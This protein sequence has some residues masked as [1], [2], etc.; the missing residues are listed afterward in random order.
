MS[1]VE[2]T[3]SPDATVDIEDLL[4]HEG[5]LRSLA[6]RLVS[7]PAAADDVVQETWVAALASPS[8]TSATAMSM[9]GVK[10]LMRALASLS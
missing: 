6:G 1:G 5:F 10:P 2:A 9:A 4:A 3:V 7:D 8:S